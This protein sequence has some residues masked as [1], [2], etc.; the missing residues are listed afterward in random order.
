MGTLCLFCALVWVSSMVSGLRK[1]GLHSFL[2]SSQYLFYMR[3]APFYLALVVGFVACKEPELN[4]QSFWDCHHSRS[5]DTSAIS[6][7]LIGSW[8]WSRQSCF[9]TGKTIKAD[10]NIKVVFNANRR[11]KVYE[12][13]TEMTSGTWGL[14]SSDSG[15]WELELSSGSRYLNGRILLCDNHVLFNNSYIDGCDNAFTKME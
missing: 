13:T 6:G 14:K 15:T 9:T 3:F 1:A 5:L 2:I 10:K 11:F 7:K 4:I 8:L 12:N